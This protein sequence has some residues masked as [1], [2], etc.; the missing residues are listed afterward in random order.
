VHGN[1]P[2]FGDIQLVRFALGS[3]DLAVF[4]SLSFSRARG[5]VK[6]RG[7]LTVTI[8]LIVNA[9]VGLWDTYLRASKIDLTHGL[10]RQSPRYKQGRP[11]VLENQKTTA[12]QTRLQSGPR[13]PRAI[14]MA[15]GALFQIFPNGRADRR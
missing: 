12:R 1:P 13:N 3:F 14:E 8:M 2:L 15:A 9:I 4:G 7:Q 11:D 10:P 5:A 6:E